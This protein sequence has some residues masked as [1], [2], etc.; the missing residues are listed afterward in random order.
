MS[1]AAEHAALKEIDFRNLI[2]RVE[3]QHSATEE[4]RL[5]LAVQAFG[6]QDL[7]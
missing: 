3:L 5:T 7:K 2:E 6:R 4:M 1:V